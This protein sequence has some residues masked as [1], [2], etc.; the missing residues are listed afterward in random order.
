MTTIYATNKHYT[1][2]QFNAIRLSIN[3]D[4]EVVCK[5]DL[6][7]EAVRMMVED[8]VEFM[9]EDK[10]IKRN[11]RNDLK[12]EV[13]A[14]VLQFVQKQTY[15]LKEKARVRAEKE[16]ER[17]KEYAEWTAVHGETEFV[18]KYFGFVI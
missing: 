17:A 10:L 12:S 3:Y 4:G 11:T 13:N 5:Y 6:T 8:F 9:V 18:E 15:E 14:V 2:E 1:I 16:L 7:D